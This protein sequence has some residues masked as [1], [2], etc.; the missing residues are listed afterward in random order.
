MRPMPRAGRHLVI[1][2][3]VVAAALGFIGGAGGPAAAQAVLQSSK[4]VCDNAVFRRL[5]TLNTLFPNLDAATHVTGTDRA[6]LQTE[7]ATTASG[8]T[9]LK[10][11]IDADTTLLKV[12]ADCRLIVTRYRVDAFLVPQVQM[13]RSADRIESALDS[14]GHL[15]LALQGRIAA[16]S[17][18]GRDVTAARGFVGDLVLKIAATST[19][20]SGVPGSLLALQASGYPGN[21]PALLSARSS[22]ATGSGDLRGALSDANQAVAALAALA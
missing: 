16:A 12:R 11:A 10:A 18:H 13:V 14:L 20:V 15:R 8:L 2:I 21:R 4:A 19:A 5:D 17:A 1:G 3:V 7:I 9:S 22:L 6:L